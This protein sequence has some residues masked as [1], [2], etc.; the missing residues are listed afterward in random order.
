VRRRYAPSVGTWWTV[1]VGGSGFSYVLTGIGLLFF[2]EWFFQNVGTF[3]PFNRHY[4]GDLGTYVLPLGVGL[5]LA[6]RE[7]PA[8][9][10]LVGGAATAT[11]LHALNH[12]YDAINSGADPWATIQIALFVVLA[13]LL[14]WAAI[15]AARERMA[16]S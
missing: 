15:A 9:R 7:G 14:W 10:L 8:G 2:P 16:A 6:A 11:S 3:P 4:T 1:V 13:G 5:L 12:V